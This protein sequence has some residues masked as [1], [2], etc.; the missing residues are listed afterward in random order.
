MAKPVPNQF[1]L[2]KT[3]RFLPLF[4][5]LFFGALNDQVFK[6]AFLAL[7]AFAVA[8]TVDGGSVVPFAGTSLGLDAFSLI[9]AILFILPFA[10]I[11]PTAGQIA[12]GL[13]KRMVIRL[14]KTAEIVVMIAAVV[15]YVHRQVEL[16]LLVLFLLGAQSAVFAP[17]KYAVL[18]QYL[19]REEL[20]GGNGLVQAATF[21]AIIFGT[22]L[23]TQV[24]LIPDIGVAAASATVMAIAFAGCAAAF[25]APAAPP[26]GK[27]PK[28]DWLF[29]RA[30]WTLV[31][32]CRAKRAP[33]AAILLIAWFWFM[34]ATFMSLLGAY[35][36]AVLQADKDVLT[37]LLA[38]F[39]VGVAIGALLANR[40]ARGGG[41]LGAT[42]WAALGLGGLAVLLWFA[43]P[44]NAPDAG[45]SL[46]EFAGTA[47][48]IAVFLCFIGLAVAAGIYVTP[49]NALLQRTAP[50]SRRA[51]FVACSNVIDA[52]AMLFSGLVGLVL[53]AAGFVSVDIFAALG[54]TAVPMAAMCARLTPGHALRFAFRGATRADE[55]EPAG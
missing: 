33:F 39:S 6:N 8:V 31:L 21:I 16:L 44:R 30:A 1:A 3:R 41:G 18:P 20:L 53:G 34:G 7:V 47:Q 24:I 14:V 22:I 4:L 45:V 35:T 42:P 19:K 2:L 49:L 37:A 23:G 10:L 38:C 28:V 27:P 48:G 43:T 25:A 54:L 46:A 15:C 12:D 40:I 29:P 9:A 36:R 50:P 26:I 13:D 52:A 32:S 55:N 11:A 51:Q 17:V 5:V